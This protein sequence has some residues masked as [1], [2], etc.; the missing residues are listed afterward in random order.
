MLRPHCLL[1]AAAATAVVLAC[2]GCFTLNAELPG[3]L[4]GDVN[5]ED[6]EKVGDLQIEKG[7]WFFI[8]GLVGEPPRDFLAAEIKKQVQAKGGDG[9][10]RLRYESEFGCLDL[11]IEGCTFSIIAPRTYRVSG[12]IVRIKK[13]PLPGK[14]AKVASSPTAAPVVVA[15]QRF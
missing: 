12:E 14:P 3:S 7:H 15:T 5:A 4:R 8:G 6:V 11:A 9:V 1:V 2:S 10:N 13:A